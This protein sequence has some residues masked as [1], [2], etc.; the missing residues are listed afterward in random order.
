M[1]PK[2][3]LLSAICRHAVSRTPKK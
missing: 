1:E 3:Y 2:R